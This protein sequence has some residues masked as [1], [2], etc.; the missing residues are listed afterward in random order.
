MTCSLGTGGFSLLC[1]CCAGPQHVIMFPNPLANSAPGDQTSQLYSASTGDPYMKL[2]DRLH[3]VIYSERKKKKKFLFTWPL[4]SLLGGGSIKVPQGSLRA[5]LI[6]RR[7]RNSTSHFT[8]RR[9]CLGLTVA[10]SLLSLYVMWIGLVNVFTPVNAD[11]NYICMWVAIFF[12]NT[13]VNK[14]VRR[15]DAHTRTL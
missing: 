15:R 7:A 3:G 2:L 5:I 14:I 8:S 12:F 13:L 6:G 10:S 4:G 9:A 11:S 1:L